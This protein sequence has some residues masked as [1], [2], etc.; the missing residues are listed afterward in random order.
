[1]SDISLFIQAKLKQLITQA[2]S[3]TSTSHAITSVQVSGTASRAQPLS[4]M[5][6]DSLF[7]VRPAVLPNQSA[8]AMR[9]ALG[10]NDGS[11]HEVHF[12]ERHIDDPRWQIL[13]MLAERST[14]RE[15]LMFS[16]VLR[17]PESVPYSE[18]AA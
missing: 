17:Q 14:V 15:A 7:S 1:M 16:A 5:S 11:D 13:A 8:A 4:A 6:F 2:L 12:K 10:E 9:L 3:L 18:K